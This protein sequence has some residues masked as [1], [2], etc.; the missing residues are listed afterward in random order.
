[1]MHALCVLLLYFVTESASAA[2][3]SDG[4]RAYQKSDFKKSET[5]LNQALSSTKKPNT[6]AEIFKYLGM[7][8]YSLKAKDRAEQSFLQAKKLKPSIAISGDEVLDP[9]VIAFFDAVKSNATGSDSLPKATGQAQKSLR[10][11]QKAKAQ[12]TTLLIESNVKNASVVMS[13]ILVGQTQAILE[14]D[15]GPVLMEVSSP[16]YQKKVIKTKIEKNAANKLTVNLEKKQLKP[17]RKIAKPLEIASA[18]DKSI[19]NGAEKGAV[20]SVNMPKKTT[21]NDDLFKEAAEP[22]PAVAQLQPPA[23]QQP[24]QAQQ[25]QVLPS[26]AQ[27]PVYTAQPPTPAYQLPQVIYQQQPVYSAPMYPP[28]YPQPYPQQQMYPPPPVYDPYAGTSVPP[29]PQPQPNYTYSAEPPSKLAEP[30]K[31]AAKASAG[32]PFISILPFGAGQFQNHSYFKGSLFLISEAGALYFWQT[33][34]A[35]AT[36]ATSQLSSDMNDFDAQIAAAPDVPT[37]AFYQNQ[38]D[39]RQTELQGYI[40]TSNNNATLSLEVFGGLYLLGVADAFIFAPDRT[41]PPKKKKKKVRR[42]GFT[43]DIKHLDKKDFFAMQMVVDSNEENALRFGIGSS[44]RGE[45]ML[46]LAVDL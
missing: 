16:G 5:S 37:K 30:K 42:S 17:A 18:S 12:S 28:M 20:K 19:E 22:L 7:V 11:G 1:M 23:L 3:F 46:G 31:K 36:Q 29:L 6:R 4:V 14:V 15:S 43:L 39:A 8:Q 27:P 44:A 35:A 2:T 26:A 40:T 13:G 34:S 10:P 24:G 33:N 25:A 21:N 9:S 45:L 41:P 38:K 32:S